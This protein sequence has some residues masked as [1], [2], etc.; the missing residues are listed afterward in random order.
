MVLEAQYFHPTVLI[1][2]QKCFYN[3]VSEQEAV[4]FGSHKIFFNGD[5]FICNLK[6]CRY[7]VTPSVR[8]MKP[9][10]TDTASEAKWIL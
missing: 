1:R 8:F 4:Q 6:I 7:T 9:F 3:H 5:D 2:W 10:R